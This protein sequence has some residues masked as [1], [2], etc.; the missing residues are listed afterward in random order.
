MPP[1]LLIPNMSVNESLKFDAVVLFY[2]SALL[3]DLSIVPIVTVCLVNHFG[4]SSQL[5]FL[6]NLCK[7]APS[8]TALK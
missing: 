4:Q 2:Y 3:G 7:S 8:S 1:T 5:Y 6:R